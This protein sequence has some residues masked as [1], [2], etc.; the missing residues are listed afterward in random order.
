MKISVLTVCRNAEGTI[1]RTIASFLSQ[2]YAQKE[3]IVID[4]ASNDRT[5]AIAEGLQSPHVRI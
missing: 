4:G 3:M 2:D 5:V 1:E